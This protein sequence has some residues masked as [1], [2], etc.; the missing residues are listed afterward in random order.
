MFP[1]LHPGDVLLFDRLAF[2]GAS[3]DRGDV[4]VFQHASA[5]SG[6]MVKMVVGLPGERVEV[7]ADRLWV[8]GRELVY[9]MPMVGS[10][11]GRWTLGPGQF[12]MLSA[13]VAV[14][15]DSRSFGPVTADALLGRAWRILPPSPRAGRL[16]DQR[17]SLR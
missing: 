3:A 5:P 8:D 4:V 16:P 6:R 11:P 12:F 17:L 13:A 2:A 1:I 14:G 7:R 10:L 15:S 9:P